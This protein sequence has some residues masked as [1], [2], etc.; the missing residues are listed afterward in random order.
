MGVT[1]PMRG[2]MALV[3]LFISVALGGGAQAEPSEAEG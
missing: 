3:V 2:R 1:L